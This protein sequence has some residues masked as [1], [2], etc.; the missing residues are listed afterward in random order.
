MENP[1]LDELLTS[2]NFLLQCTKELACEEY[3][4]KYDHDYRF[5]RFYPHLMNA[6]TAKDWVKDCEKNFN[7]LLAKKKIWDFTNEIC[8]RLWVERVGVKNGLD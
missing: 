4:L 8:E 5:S 1:Y 2:F 6:W 7:W 3:V